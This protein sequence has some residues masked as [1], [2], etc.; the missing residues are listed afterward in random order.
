MPVASVAGRAV[1]AVLEQPDRQRWTIL[2]AVL[3]E[4][5]AAQWAS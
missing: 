1:R 2:D 4:V 3:D 5:H